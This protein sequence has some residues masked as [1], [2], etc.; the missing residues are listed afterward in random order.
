MR[1]DSNFMFT[2]DDS[3]KAVYSSDLDSVLENLGLAEKFINGCI[4]CR[5]C[6]RT[7]T[8]ENLYALM[9]VNS[10]IDFCCNQP[11]CILSLAEEAQK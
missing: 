9:P 10:A 2:K 8:K 4:I 5:Y 11:K 3:L 1:G 6:Q 7:I